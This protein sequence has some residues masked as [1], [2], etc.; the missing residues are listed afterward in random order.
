[1]N[2]FGDRLRSLRNDK[3]ITG[4]QLGKVLNVTK[5]AVSKWESGDR[6]PNYDILIRIANYFDVTVDYL[7]GTSDFRNA[8]D[9]TEKLIKKLKKS[10][11]IS[12]DPTDSEIEKIIIAVK[13]Y[14]SIKKMMS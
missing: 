6:T 13:T 1:M 12:E 8:K 2:E 4:E 3:G 7:L 14:S 10:G 9:T 5:V 11:L